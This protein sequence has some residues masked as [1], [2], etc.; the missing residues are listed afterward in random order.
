M[1]NVFY[2]KML[3]Y[4][5]A[6]GPASINSHHLKKFCGIEAAAVDSLECQR[7]LSGGVSS[8]A[9]RPSLGQTGVEV[10]QGFLLRPA[11]PVASRVFTRP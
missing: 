2:A 4:Y 6:L 7:R 1:P 11:I 10:G 9:S 3:E 8:P 5:F